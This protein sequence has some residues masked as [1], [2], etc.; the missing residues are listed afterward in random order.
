MQKNNKVCK[1]FKLSKYLSSS[2]ILLKDWCI[3]SVKGKDALNYLQGQLTIDVLSVTNNTYKI[4]A[5]CNVNGKTLSNL[6]LFKYK[7]DFAYIIRKNIISIQTKEL[8]KYSIFS[9]VKITY[10][11]DLVILGIVKCDIKKLFPENFFELTKAKNNFIQKENLYILRLVDPI[12]RFIVITSAEKAKLLQNKLL[13]MVTIYHS[14]QWLIL[15]IEAN[16]P[17]IDKKSIG[18]FL[19]Q[20]L[21]LNNFNGINFKKG[22]Y[23]GQ[24]IIAKTKFFNSNKKNMYHLH[25]QYSSLPNKNELLE[26]K[27]NN[28][29]IPL[30][31]II[32]FSKLENNKIIIQA[33]LKEDLLKMSKIIKIEKDLENN[34][35]ILSKK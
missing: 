9:D 4:C 25:G 2:L 20:S 10:E 27:I 23:L 35:L 24:E 21:N 3:I 29:W 28:K 7:K 5:H 30:G 14:N 31:N 19:P 22:C 26:I 1:N 16:L 17:I 32:A 15:D 8:K 13:N 34:I 6:Y 18:K 11:T 33:I 12:E